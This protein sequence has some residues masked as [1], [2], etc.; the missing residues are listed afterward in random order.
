MTKKRKQRH[1]KARLAT[2]L[3]I[4]VGLPVWAGPG[5]LYSSAAYAREAALDYCQNHT[6]ETGDEAATT[7]YQ[8]ASGSWSF[9]PVQDIG[10]DGGNY[11][12][13]NPGGTTLDAVEHSHTA[14]M[15]PGQASSDDMGFSSRYGVT[16]FIVDTDG[17]RYWVNPESDPDRTNPYDPDNPSDSDQCKDQTG[18]QCGGGNGSP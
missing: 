6:L 9:T 10:P 16:V 13:N 15:V 3:G 1:K 14:D 5:D 12:P 17:G 2:A 8:T 18:G 4:A 7:T 11:H